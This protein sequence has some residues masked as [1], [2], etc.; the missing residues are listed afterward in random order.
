MYGQRL[1]EIYDRLYGHGLGKDYAS[2]AV[3]LA[4]VIRA[5]TPRAA[6]VL[7]VACG[8]GEHLRHLR[9][10][11]DEVA[12]L[13]LSAPMRAAAEAKLPGVPVYAGDMRDFRLART[14]DAVLCLFSSI[15]Y[16]RSA[17][18]LAAAT[19]A[20]AAH[21]TAGGVLVVEP[22]IYPEDW[23]DNRVHH[24]VA[25]FDGGTVVRVG[26]SGRDGRTSRLLM[27]YLVGDAGG[28]E[29]FSD[30]HELTLFTAEEYAQAIRAAGGHRIEFLPGWTPGRGRIVASKA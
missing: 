25:E 18:E 2:E 24:T 7:D 27:H 17:G 28:I 15:G 23:R 11:F 14:F 16:A 4:Q 13:E 6:S 10:L 1:A 29:H 9:E 5:R 22:W 12:G 8:T 30:V 3:D 26:H 19:A 20:M 21:L